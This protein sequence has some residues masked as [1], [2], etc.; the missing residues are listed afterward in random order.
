MTRKMKRLWLYLLLSSFTLSN[1]YAQPPGGGPPPRAGERIEALYIAYISRELKLSETEAQK[2]WP[3]QAEFDEEM[4]SVH[5]K[6]NLTQLEREEELLS[7]KKKYQERFVKVLG[8]TRTD[9]FYRIDTE[10]KNKLVE[11]LRKMREQKQ[12]NSNTMSD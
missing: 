11:R 10:F 8:K 4:R 9:E 12:K 3:V 2:F 1:T 7:I 6:R 5:K